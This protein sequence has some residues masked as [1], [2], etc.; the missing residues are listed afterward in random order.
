MPVIYIASGL[1]LFFYAQPILR[2]SQESFGR[3]Q[4]LKSFRLLNK[5]YEPHGRDS[6]CL[7]ERSAHAHAGIPL[8]RKFCQENCL[9]ARKPSLFEEMRFIVFI[10]YFY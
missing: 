10:L 3:Q 4:Y 7:Q 8:S 1:Y 2:V 6:R 9:H 5:S